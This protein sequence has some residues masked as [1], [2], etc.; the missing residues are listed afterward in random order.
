[1]KKILGIVVLG[2]L[3]TNSLYAETLGTDKTVNDY[4]NNDYTIVSV[5]TID[6]TNLVYTLRSNAK[7][8]PLVVSCIYSPTKKVTICFKP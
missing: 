2:L 7:K 6:R 3:F 8:K 5:D 1:M 4:V